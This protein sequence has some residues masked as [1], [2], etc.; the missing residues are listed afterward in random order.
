MFS[1][2]AEKLIAL[3]F[4]ATVAQK[5]IARII[6]LGELVRIEFFHLRHYPA[7][8][9]DIAFLLCALSGEATHLVTY[10]PHLTDLQPHY[11]LCLCAP[12]RFPTDVR[13]TR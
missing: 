3:G 6:H 1:E 9:D 11:S 7:D 10:D 4:D 2:Y 12:V 8:T 13:V 5:F